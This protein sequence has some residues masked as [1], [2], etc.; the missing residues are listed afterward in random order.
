[1]FTGRL[2]Q[3]IRLSVFDQKWLDR[4]TLSQNNMNSKTLK[5]WLWYMYLLTIA[6]CCGSMYL[7]HPPRL[8][9]ALPS[10][11]ATRDREPLM[12]RC[13]Q[14]DDRL[15]L[16]IALRVLCTFSPQRPPLDLHGK[17]CHF[18]I[19]IVDSITGGAVF[20][21]ASHCTPRHFANAEVLQNTRPLPE[22]VG[23]PNL[24]SQSSL[25]VVSLAGPTTSRI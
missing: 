4:R 25:R 11:P 8:V 15:L 24:H 7:Y 18:L 10:T 17:I 12:A 1:L 20:Y 2:K 16:G 14:Y 13:T 19:L 6:D 21:A 22:P 9:P 5:Q 23:T 3:N